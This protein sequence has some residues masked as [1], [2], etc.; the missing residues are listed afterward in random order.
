MRSKNYLF[1]PRARISL[2]KQVEKQSIG[3]VGRKHTRAVELAREFVLARTPDVL[4]IVLHGSVARGD[5]GPFSDVD[6]TAIVNNDFAS[7]EKC[8]AMRF[9]KFFDDILVT[10]GFW[11][12][13]DFVAAFGSRD[14]W[15][16]LWKKVYIQPSKPIHDPLNLWDEIRKTCLIQ[17]TRDIL[18]NIVYTFL[19]GALV[20]LCKLK[21]AEAR[22]DRREI[23]D[24]GKII[25]HNIGYLTMAIN[26]LYPVSWKTIANQLLEA[27]VKC[28]NFETDYDLAAGYASGASSRSVATAAFR[29]VL[30][31]QELLRTHF[32]AGINHEFLGE[33]LQKDLEYLRPYN[34]R[35]QSR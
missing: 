29:L 9:T 3:Y 30:Q 14:P 4:L 5:N 13:S 7:K 21:N 10:V 11:R 20:Y 12:I 28:R 17:V 24:C 8:L 16:V 15:E 19:A 26:D 33:L 22:A 27:R 32:S 6:L 25:A 23:L 1:C 2:R 31:T 35:R 34:R 18:E